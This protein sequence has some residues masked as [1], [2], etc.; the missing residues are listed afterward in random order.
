MSIGRPIAEHR[1][2]EDLA[3]VREIDRHRDDFVASARHVGRNEVGRPACTRRRLDA[4]H[5]DRPGIAEHLGDAV[6]VFNEVLLPVG[7][8]RF[9]LSDTVPPEF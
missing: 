6:G 5:G 7:H 2:A 8:A 1:L 4:E 9:T 3:D